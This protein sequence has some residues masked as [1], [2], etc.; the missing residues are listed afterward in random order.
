MAT[1][2]L[3][4]D[5]GPSPELPS[6]TAI[7]GY[8][9]DI[10]LWAGNKQSSTPEHIRQIEGLIRDFSRVQ[11]DEKRQVTLDDKTGWNLNRQ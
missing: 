10:L 8:L 2:G 9:H 3:E 7:L 6:N 4:D 1:Q 11:I 5:S